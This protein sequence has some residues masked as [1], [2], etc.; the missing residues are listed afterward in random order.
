V[1]DWFFVIFLERRRKK[2][3]ITKIL[4]EKGLI[5]RTSDVEIHITE[6]PQYILLSR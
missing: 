1:I 4:L 3:E 5:E 6:N 2:M